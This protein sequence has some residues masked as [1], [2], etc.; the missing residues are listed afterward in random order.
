MS[1]QKTLKARVCWR[2]K[3]PMAVTPIY[4]AYWHLKCF[5]RASDAEKNRARE[6]MAA[7]MGKRVL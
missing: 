4:G 1:E 6:E 5:R 2:C 7:E 3:R